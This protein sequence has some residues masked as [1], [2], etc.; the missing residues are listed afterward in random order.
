M[1]ALGRSSIR[2][3]LR[4]GALP[5]RHIHATPIALKKKKGQALDDDFFNDELVEDLIPSGVAPSPPPAASPTPIVAST[6]TSTSPATPTKVETRHLSPAARLHKFNVLVQFVRPRIGR[7]PKKRSPLVRKSAFPQLIQLATTPAQIHTITEL[8]AIW[9]EGK[10]GT[11]GKARIGPDGQPKGANPFTEPTSELFA[12]RCEELKIP[13]HAL[14]VYGSFATYSL[15]LTLPAGRS[16]LHGLVAAERPFADI[17]TA[18]ALYPSYGL[19][20]VQEDLTSCALVLSASLRHLKTTEEGSKA[21]KNIE[22]LVNELVAALQAR[23][24]KTPPMPES[25]S[26]QEKTV[27]TWLKGITRE[28]D[29]FLRTTD[30]SR[31]WLQ[32]WMAKSRFLPTPN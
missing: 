10:L 8:M 15:P 26:V 28:L 32:R 1:N 31:K 17:V 22:L 2:I 21:R 16:L 6:S 27:R 18:T 13:E 14:T 19:A 5:S 11:Q 20:P 25:R 29:E 23:L 9:K 4:P 12:R 24:T 7:T 30:G 3:L